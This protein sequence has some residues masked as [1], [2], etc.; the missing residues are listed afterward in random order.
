VA[1]WTGRWPFVA[2]ATVFATATLV[3]FCLG[4]SGAGPSSG[5]GGGGG[6]SSGLAG[7]SGLGGHAGGS[8]GS[9]GGS[10]GSAGGSGGSAGGSTGGAPGTGGGSGGTRDASTAPDRP[11]GSCYGACLETLFA[12]C[13]WRGMACVS[14]MIETDISH[15][16]NTTCYG[17]G[18]KRQETLNGSMDTVTVKT[19]SGEVCY[20][21]SYNGTGT[22]SISDGTQSVVAQIDFGD[23]STSLTV[24]CHDGSSFHTDTT[25]SQCMAYS[26]KTT[27]VT[28]A[29]SW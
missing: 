13:Q 17:N 18:V 27:C 6:G 21:T 25:S 1:L 3:A 29:C 7:Q 9:A 11:L 22:E 4:C 2:T 10:G 5:T 15:W 16:T 8:G 24:D 20:Q 26:P 19:V 23:S 28:G 12:Q 14:T